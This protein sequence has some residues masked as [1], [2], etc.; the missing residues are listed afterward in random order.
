MQG[1]NAERALSVGFGNPNPPE[2]CR[3]GIE[4]QGVDQAQAFRGRE[5]FHPIDP[6]GSAP[7]IIL[8][9]PAHGQTFGSPGFQQ[10]SLQ[11]A[12]VLTSSR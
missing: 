5:G 6:G 12:T 2:R 1:R 8:S 10:E 11:L 9:D 7:L 4:A 3:F